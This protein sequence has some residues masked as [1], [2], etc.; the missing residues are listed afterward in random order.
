MHYYTI[1]GTTTLIGECQTTVSS[2]ISGS[3]K[4]ERENS[5]SLIHPKLQAKSRSYKNSG[6]LN[7]DKAFL[8]EVHE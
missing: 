3:S 2:L 4:G 7:I 8:E 6:I 1:D 5:L